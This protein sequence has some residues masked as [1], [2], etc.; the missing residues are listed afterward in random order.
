LSVA[1]IWVSQ[2][3]QARGPVESV[4]ESG[5]SL[6]VVLLMA[7]GIGSPFCLCRMVFTCLLEP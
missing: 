7:D 4:F 6:P 5:L 1:H 3:M 2:G